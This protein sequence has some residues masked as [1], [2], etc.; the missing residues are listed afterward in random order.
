M[1]NTWSPEAKKFVC[2]LRLEQYKYKD[3]LTESESRFGVRTSKATLSK[4]FNSSEG[5]SLLYTVQRELSEKY[6]GEPLAEKYSRIHALVEA[7]TKLRNWVRVHKPGDKEYT[8]T[9]RLYLDNLVKLREETEPLRLEV[10][11]LTAESPLT[12]I[13]EFLIAEGFI[14]EGDPDKES[15][16]H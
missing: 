9:H 2:Q 13:E 5:E 16:I 3:I 6:K 11:D 8:A 14:K 10:A 4:F 15:S 7:A 1:L 12:G